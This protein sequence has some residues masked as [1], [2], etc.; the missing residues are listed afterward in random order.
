VRGCRGGAS[1]TTRSSTFSR[2]RSRYARSFERTLEVF[3]E[4]LRPEASPFMALFDRDQLPARSTLSRDFSALTQE[5][6]EALRA[7]FLDDL[8]S[9]PLSKERQTGDLVDRENCEWV[10]FDI[11]GT[12]EAACVS[13]P[14]PERRAATCLSPVGESLCSWL[15]IP[16]AWG[17]R[18]DPHRRKL[19]PQ[20]KVGS[21]RL[22]TEATGSTGR[23][24]AR[25]SGPS[26][27]PRLCTSSPRSV[28][29]LRLDGQYGTGAVLADLAGFSSVPRGKEYVVLDHPLVQAR[30]H[31]PKDSAPASSG[32]PAGAQPLRLP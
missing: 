8:E 12:R 15:D 11:D 2:S 16:Q 23:N 29:L 21:A 30:L 5:P 14:A 32:K 22:A 24:C 13:C 1:G 28:R 4:G 19:R 31:L 3:Y 17:S 20:L 7:L 9:R 18:A 25:P 6:V 27:A 26:V 10:V